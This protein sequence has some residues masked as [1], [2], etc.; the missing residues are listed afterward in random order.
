VPGLRG[1]QTVYLLL[2]VF[3]LVTE[4]LVLR[5]VESLM[6]SEGQDGNRGD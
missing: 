5:K 6:R 2:G 4:L 1:Y 3:V